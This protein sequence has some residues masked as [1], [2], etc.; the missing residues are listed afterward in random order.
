M[1]VQH[2]FTVDVPVEQAWNAVSGADAVAASLPRAQL[3]AVDGVHAGRVELDPDHDVW[4]EGRIVAIDQDDDEHVATIAL[5]GRQVNGPGIGSAL[6]RSHVA[7]SSGSSSKVELSAE[8]SSSGHESGNG[9]EQAAARLLDQVAQGLEKRARE[10]PA[11][12]K[13]AGAQ[14]RPSLGAA[15]MSPAG[16][17][18]KHVPALAA[19]GLG[20]A[21]AVIGVIAVRRRGGA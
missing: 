1:R 8:I 4:C 16:P 11:P 20:A 13:P 15:P 12:A 6:L 5:H 10:L 17:A 2:D 14:E 18:R 3:R 21:A 19:V 7:R 9:F